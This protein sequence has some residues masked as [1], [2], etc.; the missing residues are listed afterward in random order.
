[1]TSTDVYLSLY[2]GDATP[3]STVI[4]PFNSVEKYED[5]YLKI[6]ELQG[7][8]DN[9]E[10]EK[11]NKISELSQREDSIRILNEEKTTLQEKIEELGIEN[12]KL[13]DN[14]ATLEADKNQLEE[15]VI[16]TDGKI[17]EY[18]NSIEE[19]QRLNKYYT[20]Q[21]SELSTQINGRDQ[22]V[23][24]QIEALKSENKD[25]QNELDEKIELLATANSEKKKLEENSKT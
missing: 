21:I 7:Q 19:L 24:K 1:M 25:I 23:V 5:Q 3:D 6:Q 18:E 11:N 15:F 9:L 2:T 20:A 8:I 16:D 10:I 12:Q 13:A 22:D 4:D 17:T 14:Y